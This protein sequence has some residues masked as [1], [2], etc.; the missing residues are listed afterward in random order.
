M[1]VTGVVDM[2]IASCTFHFACQFVWCDRGR[3]G[4]FRDRVSG[5][6]RFVRNW[7]FAR[8]FIAS[9]LLRSSLF[10]G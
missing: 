3:D 5:R 2:V 7:M 9:A 8:V 10:G 4:W 1:T 6:T